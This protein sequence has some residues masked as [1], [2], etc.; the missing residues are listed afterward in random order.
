[1]V[2][3]LRGRAFKEEPRAAL[4]ELRD[5]RLVESRPRLLLPHGERD[6]SLRQ[7]ARE[8]LPAPGKPENRDAP[9]QRVPLSGMI[10]LPPDFRPKAFASRTAAE[11]VQTGAGQLTHRSFRVESPRTAKKIARIQNWMMTRDPAH[12][13]R[14]QWW[15]SAA[16][17]NLPRPSAM[18]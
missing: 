15:W 13:A 3:E 14:T 10:R 2:E 4:L 6:S 12:A 8:R 16:I 5:L 1:A 7:R 9:G 11:R 18:T 17:A